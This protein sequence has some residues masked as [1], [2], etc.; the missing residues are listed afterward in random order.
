MIPKIAHISW[1]DKDVIN[2]PSPLI[3]HGLKNFHALNPDWTIQISNTQ[4]VDQYLQA[5]L[6]ARDWALFDRTH[7]VERLDFWR[8]LKIYNEG[9]VYMDIDRFCNRSFD[10]ILQPNTQWVLPTQNEFDF[11]QDFMMSSPHNPAFGLALDLALS[12][13]RA[14]ERN[15]YYLGPQTYMHAVTRSLCGQEIN[16]NPGTVVFE[17]IRAVIAQHPFIV[18]YR[19]NG[20]YD[21]VIYQRDSYSDNLD[22]VTLKREFYQSYGIGHWAGEW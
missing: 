2:N 18:T 15:T 13:R 7:I 1:D 6:G 21:S 8:L 19:E 5:A 11:S 10:S 20:P 14:G 9:G 4:E 3:V 12:R 22:F 16:T 17:Q